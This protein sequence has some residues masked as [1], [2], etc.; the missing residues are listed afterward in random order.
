MKFRLLL[1]IFA[2]AFIVGCSNSDGKKSTGGSTE[3]ENAIADKTIAGVSQKGPF[4]NGSTVILHEV[5][6]NMVQTGKNFTGKIASD[7]GEF[8]IS[9]INLEAPYALL[10]ADGFYWNEVTGKRSASQINLNALTDLSDRET[11]NI[12]LLT[13]LAYERTQWLVRNKSMSIGEAKLRAES[14]ISAAFGV[15]SFSQKF[16]D[17]NIFSN[18]E[19]DDA[20]LAISV[21]MQLNCTE[22]EFIERLANF[23][24]DLEEDGTW[25]NDKLKATLADNTFEANIQKI[26]KN[27]E[28][29]DFADTVPA[30][31]PVMEAFWNDTYGLG[32]CN[33]KRDGALL[34]DTSENSAYY[35]S[36]FRCLDGHWILDQKHFNGDSIEFPI[37]TLDTIEELDCTGSM[38]CAKNCMNVMDPDLGR[39]CSRV[40]TQI[41]DGSDS[42]GLFFT[43]TDSASSF[44]WPAGDRGYGYEAASRDKYGYIYTIVSLGDS[45]PYARIAFEVSGEEQLG[46]DLTKW[47]GVCITYTANESFFVNI[48]FPNDNKIAEYDYYK[49][50]I[51]ATEK[52]VTA[53]IQ[54]SDFIQEGFG[55]HVERDSVIKNIS[56]IEI[57]FEKP[58]ARISSKIHSIS[59][60]GTC[61]K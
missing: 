21:M 17:L 8:N 2:A 61:N 53:N 46:N 55:L 43:Y 15:S 39:T 25:D 4:V 50:Q 60:Y 59:K 23:A 19:G 10:E 3:A 11:A 58:G 38:Y 18:G 34:P 45:H 5:D 26:R 28:A 22:A 14:E 56:R 49:A 1:A 35:R 36:I 20:L 54:W 29:W 7:K 12:N 30:F 13:H 16:E 27:I 48:R 41:D 24:T 42:Y 6:E 40:N 31:E 51:P 57:S 33:K 9:N 44:S 32:K 52:L 37:V 47:G